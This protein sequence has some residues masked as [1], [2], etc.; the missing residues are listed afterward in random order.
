MSDER[1]ENRILP[2]NQFPVLRILE[3]A[4]VALSP[5]SIALATVTAVLLGFSGWIVDRIFHVDPAKS[6]P[7]LVIS[8][9][10]LEFSANEVIISPWTSV[11]QPAVLAVTSGAGISGRLNGLLR[12][13][14]ALGAWSL[15]GVILCRRSAFLFVCNDQSTVA[16]A[17]KY[18]LRRWGDSIRSPLIP[19]AAAL[20]IG[21]IIS[22]V[23]LLGR[24]PYW[25][26]AW[27]FLISP[28][29]AVLGVVM[30][31]LLLAT[32]LAWPLMVAAVAI[33]DCESFGGLSRAYSIL[34]SRPWQTTGY[35]IF[36]LL[37][38]LILMAV[39]MAVGETTIWCGVSATAFGSGG[40]QVRKSL[41]SPLTTLVHEIV[42]GIGISFFWSAATVIYLLLRQDVD[43]VPLDRIALDDDDRPVRDPLPVVGI[44][45]TDAKPPTDTKMESND[46]ILP[47]TDRA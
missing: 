38:G 2:R 30:A 29:V 45:A 36:G 22:G 6:W 41:V 31:F 1:A 7:P 11:A 39:T 25:G 40:E 26:S 3:A 8:V 44:P 16:R 4:G 37:V 19:L 27:L 21:I 14:L 43:G 42:T 24:L 5:G 23:G 17:V 10:G 34:T 18:G 12:F 9:F 28:I 13:G 15:V 46:E 20:L 32:M 47:I 35:I 33:D